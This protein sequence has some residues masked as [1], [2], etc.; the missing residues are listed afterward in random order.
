MFNELDVITLTEDVSEGK[1]EAKAGAI[2]TIVYTYQNHDAFM[3]EF[4]YGDAYISDLIHVLPHQARLTTEKDLEHEK[5][6]WNIAEDAS[7]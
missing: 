7:D 2:G 6:E 5:R 3:V 4:T 1:R